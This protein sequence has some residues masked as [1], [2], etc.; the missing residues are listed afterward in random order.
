MK[1]IYEII[2]A[3]GKA[4]TKAERKDILLKHKDEWALKDLLKGTFS[5]QV[6]F[7]LPTGEVPYT[8]CEEHNAPSDW[9]RQHKQLKYVVKGGPGGAMPAHKREKIFLGILES[10]HP[11]DAKLVVKMIN[12]E[13]PAKGI[14]SSLVKE[15]FP[16]LIW[17]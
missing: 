3:V 14:T 6:E 5:N 8:A 2:E 10:I 7:L 4:K 12:K 17:I 15:V 16:S 9:K 1:Y 11:E 13:Q